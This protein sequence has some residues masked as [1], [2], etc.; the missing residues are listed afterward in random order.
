MKQALLL[1][2]AQAATSA[3]P[4]T[5]THSEVYGRPLLVLPGQAPRYRGQEGREQDVTELLATNEQTGG[6][7]GIFRQT[8]APGSGPPTL[9]HRSEIE[10]VYVLNGDFKFR[11]EERVVRV[12]VGTFM[13]IPNMTPHTFKN[14]GSK[15]GVLLFGVSA[16]GMEKIFSERQA[17]IPRRTRS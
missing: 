4:T 1:L 3:A 15:P 5:A 14:V 16:G 13:F 9:F 2:L 11:L 7:L 6:K 10:F 17:L 8:V 12:P